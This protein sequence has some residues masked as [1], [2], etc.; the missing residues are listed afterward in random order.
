MCTFL[1]YVYFPFINTD[2]NENFNQLLTDLYS[3]NHLTVYMAIVVHQKDA[4][5][6]LLKESKIFT[7][8]I[9]M[10]FTALIYIYTHI[11]IYTNLRKAK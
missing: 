2:L 3:I 11:Y 8:L 4:I 10:A 6:E 7:K 5:Y 9:F 1:L